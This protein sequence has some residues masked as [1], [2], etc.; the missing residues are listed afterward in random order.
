MTT[1]VQSTIHDRVHYHD[2][3]K[4]S[5][6]TMKFA[7]SRVDVNSKCEV[8]HRRCWPSI[9]SVDHASKILN[10]I[11][12][13]ICNLLT[14]LKPQ[15]FSATLR[16]GGICKFFNQNCNQMAWKKQFNMF[17]EISYF[18]F[19]KILFENIF[20]PLKI[21]LSCSKIFFASTFLSA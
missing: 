7:F 6:K 8:F 12:S 19:K 18:L 4:L 10:Y 5:E 21:F 1:N 2:L 9:K 17:C 15:F 20:C 16:C 13:V 11:E 14:G 3:N